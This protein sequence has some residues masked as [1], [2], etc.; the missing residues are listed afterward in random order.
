MGQE[1]SEATRVGQLVADDQVATREMHRLD[2]DHAGHTT[3]PCFLELDAADAGQQVNP[4][5]LDA[6]LD[7]V[8][9]PQEVF[10]SDAGLPNPNASIT[11][12][13]RA[14]L[15]GSRRTRMSTCRCSAGGRK[16]PAPKRLR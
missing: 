14:A 15:T 16:R 9:L 6:E 13:M 12:I 4:I 10:G 2:P 1:H 7:D 5:W 3:L 8:V 11:R